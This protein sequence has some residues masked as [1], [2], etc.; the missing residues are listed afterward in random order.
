M[1][2]AGSKTLVNRHSGARV[3]ASIHLCAGKKKQKEIKERESISNEV[4]KTND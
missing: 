2:K 1:L 3:N 4:N